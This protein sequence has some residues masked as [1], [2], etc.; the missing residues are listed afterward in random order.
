MMQIVG[1]ST[2]FILR[3]DKIVTYDFGVLYIE[4]Q[5]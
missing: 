3:H 2:S 5:I 4:S 1:K